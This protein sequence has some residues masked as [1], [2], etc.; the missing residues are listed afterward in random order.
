M[1]PG[2]YHLWTI[3]CQMNQAESDRLASCLE[4][5]GYT[6]D[7]DGADAGL[8]IL[9]SCVVRQSAESRVLNKLY[10]LKALKK[11][12]PGLSIALTGCLVDSDIQSLKKR[13]PYVD[14][15]FKPGERPPWLG[16]DTPWPIVP[17][18][19]SPCVMV[20]IMQGCDNFCTY[21]IVPYRRGRE[22]SRLPAEIVSEVRELVSAGIREVTLLGQN[23]DSYGRDLPG[24]PELADLLAEINGIEGLA[25][26]RFLTSHP[27]DMSRRLIQSV[28]ALD[29]VCEQINLPVQSGDDGILKAMRRDY[30]V[31]H[32]RDLI[33][34]IRAAIPGVAITTDVIVGFPGESR[35]QFRHTCVLL[36]ELR[37]DAVHVAAYSVRPGTI[38]AREYPDDVTLAEKKARLGMVEELQGKIAGEINNRLIGQSVE[39]LVEEKDRGKWRGR[40][41]TGKLVFFSDKRHCAGELVNVKI[42]DASPWSLKG[43]ADANIN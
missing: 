28:A 2:K 26:I 19:T 12:R 39:V 42:T 5:Q 32:Y 9:N 15:F 34:E 25:R 20:T 4:A 18:V 33:A 40:T 3:G 16:E 13:F 43:E 36:E 30:T 41:R 11:S 21:C 27:R 7:A 24:R 37:F 14:H 10:R 17:Q 38:A 22:R 1:S 31:A 35:E 8:I 6:P 23:V 29:K